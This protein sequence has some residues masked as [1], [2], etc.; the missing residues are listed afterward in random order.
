M[1]YSYFHVRPQMAWLEPFFILLENLLF[2]QGGIFV[3]YEFIADDNISFYLWPK[4]AA[5]R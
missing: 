2:T 3:R 1:T 4:E 5:A